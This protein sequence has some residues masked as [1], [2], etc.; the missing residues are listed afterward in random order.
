M[1]NNLIFLAL[2]AFLLTSCATPSIK[3]NNPIGKVY[4]DSVQLR[5]KTI[6]LL[7]GEWK[8]IGRGFSG[9]NNEYFQLVL[10]KETERREM[11]S[12]II[13]AT[14]T[15]RNS[16]IGYLPCKYCNRMDVHHIAVK[17]NARGGAQDC[18]LI[19]HYQMSVN[20]KRQAIKEAYNYMISNHCTI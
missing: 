5:N 3:Q 4:K 11:H 6:P 19:N 18:W 17:N 16:Y 13:I 9:M 7:E 2:L 10:I 12:S 14:D 1:K 20:P 15:L 8:V